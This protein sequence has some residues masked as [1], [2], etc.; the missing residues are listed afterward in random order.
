MNEESVRRTNVESMSD[1]SFYRFSEFIEAE[2]GIKMPLAKKTMLQARLQKRLWKLDIESFDEYYN[3]V[4]SPEGRELELQQMIDVVT[5]N[6]T[7][8]FREPNHFEYLVERVLPEI[9]SRHGADR[10]YMFWCAGCSS[11][12]EPYSLAM[13]LHDFSLQH[14]GFHFLIL[15]TD[16]SSRVLEKARL[17]IYEEENADPIPVE[18]RKRY[19]LKSKEREKSMVRISPEIRAF[20]RFRS[21]NLVRGEFGFRETMDI[22]FCRNVIIY[23][24]RDIQE[25]V[26]NRL[27]QHLSPGGYLFTGHSETLN[28]LSVPLKAVAHTV[29]QKEVSAHLAP[30][31]PVITL[32]PAELYISDHPAIV[33]TVLGSCVAVTMFD[34]RLGVAAMCH[35]LLPQ[36]N[37]ALDQH[38]ATTENLSYKYVQTVIPLM[39][40]RLKT[41]GSEPKDLEVKLF[42]GA[43]MLT[44]RTGNPNMQPVGKSNIDAV[45]QAIKAHNLE[46]IVSDVGGHLGR[47][48]LFYTQ[49][50]EVLLKRINSASEPGWGA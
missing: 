27:Y 3:Y 5:T 10:Q 1:E 34:K 41:Y 11:G 18:F 17:G 14:P 48:I 16:V 4:F 23:F 15:A 20:V 21:V 24:N 49:T 44:V 33:R 47:K 6:K 8:F 13:V 40:Q 46:L 19:L 12:E 35:A 30:H 50:G 32:K 42:G 38:A 28:G 26:I 31:L 29:Y 36:G 22:I 43:D 2:L 7:D 9:I 45:L 37:E 25:Q 39:L